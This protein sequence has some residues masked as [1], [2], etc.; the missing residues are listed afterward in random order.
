MTMPRFGGSFAPPLSDEKLTGYKSMIDALP[1]SALK[2]ALATCLACCQK[3]WELPD[4]EGVAK[5]HPATP[6]MQVV[7]LTEANQKALWDLI[8][9]KED[10]ANIQRLFDAIPTGQKELR[11]CAFHLL[12]HVVE[13]DRDR[14]PLT[15][16]KLAP[17]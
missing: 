16:D 9:W 1:A 15:N 2:D 10:I 3:W 5:A 7:M 13:L 4:S 17:A 6:R 11:K 8:P 14:E 12:W